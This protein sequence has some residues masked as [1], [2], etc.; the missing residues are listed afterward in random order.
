M[1]LS[2]PSSLQKLQTALHARAKQ[3]P[4]YR[5]YSLYDKVHRWDA[6]TYAYILCKANHGKPGTDGQRFTDIEK[7]GLG[8]FTL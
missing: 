5:F 7:Y 3:S 2:T 1:S 8:R 6:L 4:D